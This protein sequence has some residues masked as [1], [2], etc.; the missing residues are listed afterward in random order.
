L[1]S[2][3]GG[4]GS[5]TDTQRL[6]RHI[7]TDSISI[8]HI[9]EQSHCESTYDRYTEQTSRTALD[10]FAHAQR[11][12][13]D[14]RGGRFQHRFILITTENKTN[15]QQQ[16]QQQRTTIL[17]KPIEGTSGGKLA[18]KSAADLRSFVEPDG[19][20]RLDQSLESLTR[21]THNSKR[22]SLDKRSQDR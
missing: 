14:S 2:A 10:K 7:N 1:R 15:R 11:D 4:G 9:Q 16:H 5:G 18:R 12:G 8:E 3:R 13:F 20:Q 21:N 17:N 22:R 19:G 6:A